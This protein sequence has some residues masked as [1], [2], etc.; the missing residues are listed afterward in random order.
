M[1]PEEGAAGVCGLQLMA[2]ALALGAPADGAAIVVTATGR[3]EVARDVPVAVQVI[4]AEALARAGVTDIRQLNQLAPTL[5]VSSTG[6]E[7]GATGARIR[8]IGTV[9]DNPGLESSVAT[10]VDGVYRNR[11][12]VALTELGPLA[13]IAVLRGPQGTLFG[14]NATA[15]L[16]DIETAAPRFD[17]GGAAEAS[18]GNYGLRRLVAGVTGPVAR[19]LAFRI[20]GVGMRRRGFVTDLVSGRDVNDRRRGLVRGQLLFERDDLTIRL[21]GDYA[22]RDEECCAGSYRPTRSVTRGADGG[23]VFGPNPIAA[24]VRGL[25]GTIDTDTFGR[26]TAITPGQAYRGDVRDGGLS[27]QV[28]AG[29][30]GATL[31]GISA[32]RDWRWTRG[33]DGDF[34]DL[35]ILRRDPD[36]GAG[37]RFETLSQEVRLNG[38]ALDGRIDWLVGGYAARETLAFRDNQTF[39]ADF[40]RYAS[41]LLVNG[42]APA[43]L[44]PGPAGCVDQ[45][46]L[47]ARIAAVRGLPAGDAGRTVLPLLGALA[48]DPARPGLGSLA[49]SLGLAGYDPAGRGIADRFRQRGRT[50]ALFTHNVFRLTEGLSLTLGGRYTDEGKRLRLALADDNTLCRAVAGSALAGSFALPCLLPATAAGTFAGATRRRD[51]EGTGTAA[52]AWRPAAGLLAYASWSRGFKAGGYNLERTPLARGGVIASGA[53]LAALAFA[54][55]T[56]TAWEAGV[57]L[58]RARFDLALTGFV[59][60]IRDFQ[61]N[62]YNGSSFTVESLNGCKADLGGADRDLSAATGACPAGL[63]AGVV[64][65]GVEIE[66]AVR[67]GRGF[68]LTAGMTIADT[69]Y[70]D[71]LVGTGGRALSPT[72]FQ[73]P[74]RPLSNAPRVTVTGAA[75]WTPD[76]GGGIAGLVHGDLRYQ[77]ATN[78]GSDLDVEK[79]Q[80]GVLVVGARIGLSGAGW[81]IE[82]WAQN[83][84]DVDYIQVGY[85]APLQGGGT[86]R[87]TAAFGTAATQVYGA[88]LAEPRTWGGDAA[89]GVVMF[90]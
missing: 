69:H 81:A 48:A 84:F 89:P 66:G 43:A 13:R 16:I 1:A 32:W 57:K 15:G 4:G 71:D 90:A 39:G 54:P 47:L 82:A 74:G 76:L 7:A 19:D 45:A 72:L 85:D 60:R 12:G 18:L 42:A 14:R 46:A 68:A 53:D 5:L 86:L 25:G 65:R 20:D 11:P 51:R 36:G 26:R 56:V 88:F 61:L 28:T 6:S 24:I 34:N 3:A 67:P 59:S 38:R 37:Q 2:M 31:T 63:T 8:G 62:S 30:G 41:C 58:S 73:L 40:A 50:L 9:G 44:A 17:W 70:A 22:R 75:D 35:D 29:L 83:L 27:A 10:V 87:Q 55:E 52:L 33:Q 79:I 21:I 64:A 49:G 78:T 80:P 77:S 23:L